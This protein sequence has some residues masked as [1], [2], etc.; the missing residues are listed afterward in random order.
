MEKKNE[1]R[2]S[3]TPILYILQIIFIVLKA[4]G[5]VSWSWVQVFIPTFISLSVWV[6]VGLI[7]LIAY[8]RREKQ[9]PTPRFKRPW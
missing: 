8:L 9:N 5:V 7:V 4:C 1:I 3:N 2:T 6:I